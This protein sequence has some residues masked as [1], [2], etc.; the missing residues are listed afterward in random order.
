MAIRI[1][2][3]IWAV[4][5]FFLLTGCEKW[6]DGVVNEIEFPDHEPAL[7]ASCI[8]NSGDMKAVLSVSNT[9]SL[10]STDTVS[11]PEGATAVIR[12]GNV[13]LLEW[14]ASDFEY[15]EDQKMLVVVLDA[16]LDLPVGPLELTVSAPGWDDLTATAVQ[17]PGPQLD[18][19]FEIGADT[20]LDDWSFYV[21][22]VVTMDLLNR[23]GERDVYSVR[24]EEGYVVEQ[25]TFWNQ[26]WGGDFE[27]PRL[28]YNWSCSCWLVDDQNVDEQSLND[29]QIR[30]QRWGEDT[31]YG[32]SDPVAVRLVVDLLDPSLGDFYNAVQTHEDAQGNPFANPSGIMSNTSTGYGHFG[33]AARKAILLQ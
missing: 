30:R 15:V 25:D 2:I 29:V 4:A 33:L 21:N 23:E 22:D 9:A 27:D 13:T 17:P 31:Y 8:L 11:L 18:W 24:L 26:A 14:L 19:D 10:L 20:I 6:A 32:Y 5:L 7:A 3:R 1:L 12:S 28:N 16:P